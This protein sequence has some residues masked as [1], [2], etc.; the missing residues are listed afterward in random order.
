MVCGLLRQEN[1]NYQQARQTYEQILARNPLFV[2]AARDLAILCSQ[3]FPDDSKAIDLALKARESFP[4]DPNLAKAIGVLAFR[5][6]DYARAVQMLKE[7]SQ[8]LN[9]DA[10]SLYYLGMAH[11]RLKRPE[12]SKQALQKALALNLSPQL[13]EQARRVLAEIGKPL[14][15]RS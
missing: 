1:G 8:K 6:E 5:R 15:K 11:Y 9:N 13:A 3:R 14:A 12:E 10:E 4:D 2:P 7:S